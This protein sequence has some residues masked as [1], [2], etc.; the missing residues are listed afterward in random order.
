MRDSFII[1][2]RGS[3]LA[4]WQAEY[5]QHRLQELRPDW[6]F[7]LQVIK[8]RGD[9]I[10][11]VPLAQVGGKGLFVKEIEEA[12]LENRADLAI[13]SMKDVPMELPPGLLIGCIPQRETSADCLLS[14]RYNDL[15][16]LPKGAHVG[17]S[18]LRRQAQL[19]AIRPD[20]RVSSLRGNIDT[21]LRKLHE[22][23]YDAII[24]AA[25]GLLRLGLT[26]PFMSQLDTRLFLPSVGQG[27]LGI[28]C[29]ED[30][31]D[32]FAV[33]AYM[34]D[35]ATR[36][37][38]EAERGFLAGLNGGCQVPIAGHA[39]MNDEETIRLDGLVAE[40]DG[41]RI[42]RASTT[43]NAS[44]SRQIGLDLADTLLSQGGSTI[45]DTFYQR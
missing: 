22:G 5:V 1:A 14:C 37:C 12:L 41:S 17:T 35:T 45:L 33:L 39:V 9:S 16:A 27:A 21:R 8:T 4:L 29:R 15:N 28:E 7:T 13:H 25:A 19:L 2:T 10:Q 11:N 31:Y 26:A 34:E 36:V 42:L 23:L 3:K 43:G 32:L 6:Y 20:L 24:L 44:L 18:S 38:V 40:P 30:D